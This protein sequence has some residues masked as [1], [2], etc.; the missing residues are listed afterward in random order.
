MKILAVAALQ[1][2]LAEKKSLSGKHSSKFFSA[3]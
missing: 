3:C 1:A 2:V